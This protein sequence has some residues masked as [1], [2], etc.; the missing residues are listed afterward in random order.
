MGSKL[1]YLVLLTV[2]IVIGAWWYINN[3]ASLNLSST[4]APSEKMQE[5]TSSGA[6]MEGGN[7]LNIEE[8]T[9]GE[10]VEVALAVLDSPGFIE[11]LKGDVSVGH[12]DYLHA[13]QHEELEIEIKVEMKEGETYV[14][15]LRKDDGD[16]KF[17]AVKDVKMT[18]ES[19]EVVMAKFSVGSEP[20]EETSEE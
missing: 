15:Y 2:L 11:F 4:P 20:Q 14:A 9:A 3:G 16:K 19:G 6:T 5:T 18:D 7:A 10:I 8:Q 1:F 13:G 17:D 12:S